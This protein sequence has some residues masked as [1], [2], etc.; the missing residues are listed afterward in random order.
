MKKPVKAFELTRQWGKTLTIHM[1]HEVYEGS[2]KA[3]TDC[4]ME[5]LLKSANLRQLSFDRCAFRVCICFN[6]KTY[7]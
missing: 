3:T 4:I 7:L 6:L 2:T 5:I 1:D